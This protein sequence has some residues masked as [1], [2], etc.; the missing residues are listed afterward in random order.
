MGFISRLKN[1]LQLPIRL[2]SWRQLLLESVFLGCFTAL[3]ILIFQPFGTYEYQITHKAQ[4]LLGYGL[5]VAFSYPIT[6][7]SL[8][9]LFDQDHYSLLKEILVVAVTFFLVSTVCFFYFKMVAFPGATWKDF[10]DFLIFCIAIGLLPLSISLYSRYTQGLQLKRKKQSSKR[11]KEE[12]FEL[13]GT[14]QAESYRFHE[15]DIIY[16]Q[17]SGNYVEVH[18][19][20]DDALKS[21]LLRNTLSQVIDQ[22]PTQN[23]RVVHRSYVINQRHFS[24]FTKAAGKGTIIAEKWE[25]SVPVSR[26]NLALAEQIARDFR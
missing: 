2:P 3:F 20:K 7:K 5:V 14:N 23:F 1:I 12:A 22:L 13:I 6:K 10:D 21:V 24:H 26:A 17:S 18:F 19:V 9:L 16:L 11:E 15:Q 25:I 4:R 8:T